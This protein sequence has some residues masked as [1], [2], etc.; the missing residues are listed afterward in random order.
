MTKIYTC[1]FISLF[2][3]LLLSFFI[4]NRLT[5]QVILDTEN[6]K[7]GRKTISC[8]GSTTFTDDNKGGGGLYLD[9]AARKDTIILCPSSANAQIKATFSSFDMASGDFLNVYDGDLLKNP[10]ASKTAASGNGVSKA[11]G[12]WIQANC[13]PNVNPTGC[14]TFEIE[15]NGNNS[16]GT[17]WQAKI[18]CESSDVAIQCAANISAVDDCFSLNGQVTVSIPLPTFSV[19]GSGGAMV[20]ITSSCSI[21]P[22]QTVSANGGTLGTYTL[23]LGT[24]SITA[25]LVGND[26]K[27]CTYFVIIDQP[28]ITCNDNVTSSI[29]SNCQATINVDGILEDPCVGAGITYEIEITL[30]KGKKLKA[31]VDGSSFSTLNSGSL[32]IDKEDFDCGGN[33]SVKITR[34]VSHS[35]CNG[36]TSTS[37]RSCTGQ[38]RFTDNTPPVIAVSSQTLTTCGELT[39]AAIRRKLAISAVDNCAIK[40]TTFSVGAF[41]VQFL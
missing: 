8:G 1:D 9:D 4:E 13:D 2:L 24:H 29:V 31:T 38:V 33:Y 39:D 28:T 12:G 34:N 5:A 14:L 23:P 16:K 17:G 41:P 40:D 3:L 26:S 30:K 32:R 22:D 19:C 20:N 6:G 36:G 11:F 7:N 10:G 18:S 21:I 37:S 35:D 27:A 25:T 15:T